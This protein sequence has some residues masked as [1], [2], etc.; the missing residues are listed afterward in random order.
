MIPA[1]SALQWAIAAACS[2]MV[3]LTKTGLPALATLIVPLFAMVLPARASTGALLPLLILGDAI[4]VVA[5]RRSAVW[6]HLL[7]LLPWAAAGIVAGYLLM[8][9]ID[10]RI[11]RPVLGALVLAMLGVSIWRDRAARGKLSVPT[12][13]WFAAVMGLLAGTT[14]MVA[15]AA[16][17]V[18]MIY[19]LAMRLPKEEFIGTGAWFFFFV[20]WIKVP[21]SAALGLIT[22]PSLLLDAVLAAGVVAGAAAGILAA[23]RIPQKL[24]DLSMLIL[25]AAA[26]VRMFF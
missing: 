14:T 16:G 23:R 9:R 3:G 15:N 6:P 17:P 13:W 2:V 1:L 4:A 8:G 24:F 19:L 25:T 20:N 12:H 7:R 18:M 10:D 22:V 21:F 11:M 26:A 5:Y